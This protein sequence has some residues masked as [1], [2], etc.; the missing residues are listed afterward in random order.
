VKLLITGAAGR[1]GRG[2]T[3]RLAAHHTVVALDRT[4]P[5]ASFPDNVQYVQADLRDARSV[6]SAAA[7]AEAIVHLGAIPGRVPSVPQAE[8]FQINTQGTYH[9]LEAAA[10]A[11]ARSVIL[12]GS[13]CAIGFPGAIDDHGLAYLPLDEDHP[14]RPRHAYDLSKRLNELTA[15]TFS[16][17]SGMTTICLRLPALVNVRHAPWFPFDRYDNAPRLPLADYLDM[18]DAIE[19]I[20]VA[21]Q[22]TDLHHE[23]L[24]VNAET[25]GR[26]EPTGQYIQRFSPRVEWRGDPP[27]DT[28]PLINCDRLKRVLGFTP[29]ITW[30]MFHGDASPGAPGAG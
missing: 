15:E 24:F 14:C 20:A 1:L 16:R 2:L 26:S 8:I 25:S 11:S 7:G 29:R 5:P 21:L 13:L 6:R 12:A 22:R 4:D 17:L 28:T 18:E 3:E 19:V 27:R 10:R 9:V 30:Q 23:V